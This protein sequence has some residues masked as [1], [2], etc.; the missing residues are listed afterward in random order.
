MRLTAMKLQSTNS[1]ATEAGIHLVSI[2]EEIKKR[3]K[4]LKNNGYE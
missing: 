1:L 4:E 3:Q 2:I